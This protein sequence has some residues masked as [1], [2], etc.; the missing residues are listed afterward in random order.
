MADH[1]ANHL[2]LH[3]NYTTIWWHRGERAGEEIKTLAQNTYRNA[4][5]FI[6]QK[7]YKHKKTF[8]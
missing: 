5:F 1:K 3:I 8:I 2:A 6:P 7:S 4:I